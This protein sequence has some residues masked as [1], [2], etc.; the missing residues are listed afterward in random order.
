MKNNKKVTSYSERAQ[1]SKSVVRAY[2]QIKFT[3]APA[4][5]AFAL[6]D[7]SFGKLAFSSIPS[8]EYQMQSDVDA[9]AFALAYRVQAHFL[10]TRLGW[11]SEQVRT[12]EKASKTKAGAFSVKGKRFLQSHLPAHKSVSLYDE[13][14]RL[15]ISPDSIEEAALS[16]RAVLIACW[17]LR[18]ENGKFPLETLEN[19]KVFCPAIR[20][21][22]K[23]ARIAFNRECESALP[24]FETESMG[25]LPAGLTD[26]PDR[27][28]LRVYAKS[29]REIRA[30]WKA[31]ESRKAKAGKNADLSRLREIASHSLGIASIRPIQSASYRKGLQRL[32]ERLEQ[33]SMIRSFQVSE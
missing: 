24:E 9:I 33:G 19:G 20:Q 16:A 13:K 1:I 12:M 8:R 7:E 11:S 25:Y 14:G 15:S 3:P 21:A 2:R 29:I 32:R 4:F 28:A 22:N 18:D 10:K 30:Y 31:S 5:K 26:S 6:A 23:A 17:S 27:E